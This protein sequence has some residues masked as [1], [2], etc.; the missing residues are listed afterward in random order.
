MIRCLRMT[1]GAANRGGQEPANLADPACFARP[2]RNRPGVHSRWPRLGR[3]AVL[4]TLGGLAACSR[5]GDQRP[6]IAASSICGDCDIDLQGVWTSAAGDDNVVPAGWYLECGDT[7]WTLGE[8]A[9]SRVVRF[10]LASRQSVLFDRNGEGPGEFRY[11]Q[12]AKMHP[13]N[14]TILVVHE[15]RIS[16]MTTAL[17]EARSIPNIIPYPLGMVVLRDGRFIVAATDLH[18]PAGARGNALHVF[19]PDGQYLESFRAVD[20][21][22]A[23]GAWGLDVGRESN[24]IWVVEPR[25]D[26]LIAEEWDVVSMD[27]IRVF[28]F[29][30]SW[31]VGE[32]RSPEEYE[33]MTPKTGAPKLPT[34]TVG[35]WD[36]GDVLWVVLRHFDP[37]HG[38]YDFSHTSVDDQFDAILLA[39]D[40]ESGGVL[41]TAVFDA[42]SFAFTSRG[43]LVLYDEDDRTGE[44]RIRLATLRL[45]RQR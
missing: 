14:D 3:H 31:W 4:L 34:G 19:S 18:Q 35:V 45:S 6:E 40:R 41:A 21:A 32:N 12:I 44:P 43:R 25:A 20:T 9:E 2:P 30:P 38:S 16:Y 42:F 23:G 33:Q 24:T 7:L 8:M 17:H 29:T 1:C 27:R 28:A 36:G 13:S 37:V 22:L 15:N 10:S 5:A 11:P 26:G 39:M